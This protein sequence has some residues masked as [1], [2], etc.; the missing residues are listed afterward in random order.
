[1]D[2]CRKKK[3]I[4][5]CNNKEKF[6]YFWKFV[7]LKIFFMGRF[8]LIIWWYF[9]V[10]IWICGIVDVVVLDVIVLVFV[11]VVLIVVEL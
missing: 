10:G 7:F 8:Y 5:I 6:I 4:N 3:F 2:F 11:D 1:M 9:E